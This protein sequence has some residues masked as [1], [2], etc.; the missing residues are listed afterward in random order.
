MTKSNASKDS[1][2]TGF[3][4]Q[5]PPKGATEGPGDLKERATSSFL[6]KAGTNQG[7][8]RRMPD[9]CQKSGS[10]ELERR[11]TQR[12]EGSIGALLHPKGQIDA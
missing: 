3:Q 2:A 7:V 10:K 4:E 8:R 6:D 9:Q 5:A 1:E 11:Q 12:R